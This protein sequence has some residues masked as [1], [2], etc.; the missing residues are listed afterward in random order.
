MDLL[1]FDAVDRYFGGLGAVRK[2]SFEVREG[3]ILGLIGPNGAGKSTIFNVI[4][5]VFPATAGVVTFLG[6]DITR[7]STAHVVALGM[8][9]TFQ[10]TRLFKTLTVVD[11]V[12][13]GTHCRHKT[14]A[15]DVWLRT[16]RYYRESKATQDKAEQLLE[17]AGL[18]QYA[19][20]EAS[21]LPYGDQRKLEIVRALATQPRLLL[22]DEPAA[23]MNRV[24]SDALCD[25]LRQLIKQGQTIL[26][27][28]HDMKLVMQVCDR[29]M[30]LDY[31][32]KI[33][34]GTP[35]EIQRNPKVIEAYLGVEV[36]DVAA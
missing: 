4:M 14:N 1:R 15:F 5:N 25:F 21:S 30:V 22:L 6:Q 33:A 24:E 19:N 26:L 31:G 27:I 13:T 36:T 35:A 3:E 8:G 28:E 32:E 17:M 12:R 18:S 7:S 29:I 23:G 34:E 9:R 16:R 10:N 11:N 2:V 20:A